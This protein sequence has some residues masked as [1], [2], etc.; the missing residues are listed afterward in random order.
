MG[1]AGY[2]FGSSRVTTASGESV[3]GTAP[4]DDARCARHPDAIATA[5]CARCGS[6]ACSECRVTIE[7]EPFCDDCIERART[8]REAHAKGER[9]VRRIAWSFGMIAFVG[10]LLVL[11]VIGVHFTGREPIAAVYVQAAIAGVI[12]SIAA[13]AAATIGQLTPRARSIGLVAA[14]SALLLVPC[15]TILGI[16]ALV[17]L[18]IH[19]RVFDDD[20]REAVRLSP[21]SAERPISRATKATIA[22]LVALVLITLYYLASGASR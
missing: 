9:S 8:L 2:R 20:Y 17:T 1:E 7:G 14:C 4:V 13:T 11:F 18:M 5:T 19:R 21:G 15:G 10:L 6:F 12:A 16:E 3:G 22:L